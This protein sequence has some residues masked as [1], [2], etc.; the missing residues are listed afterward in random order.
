MSKRAAALLP[1]NLP[2]VLGGCSLALRVFAFGIVFFQGCPAW[3]ESDDLMRM[4]GYALTGGD[5][6]DTRAIGD[7]VNCVFA[8]KN[9][10]FRLNDVYT[11]R[12]NIRTFQPRRGDPAAWIT[13]TLQGDG[14][15]FEQT[16]EPP[17][18]DGSETMRKMRA[19][20]PDSFR[21]RH[22]TY[23]QYELHFTT[24]DPDK[25]KTTWQYIYRYGCTGK[26]SRY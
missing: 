23:T 24:N 15:V 16:V 12:I 4:V 3:A 10:L 2:E 6:S 13:L 7:R 22:Y 18:D 9:E 21:T 8:I 19:E 26:Q 11:D 17:N 20:Y 25:V 5:N 1:S 14:T